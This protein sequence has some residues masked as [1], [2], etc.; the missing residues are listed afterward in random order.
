MI[1]RAILGIVLCATLVF[2][3]QYTIAQTV[4]SDLFHEKGFPFLPFE[5]LLE[6]PQNTGYLLHALPSPVVKNSPN[7]LKS[8]LKAYSEKN[9]RESK[10]YTTDSTAFYYSGTNDNSDKYVTNMVNFN[11]IVSFT[12]YSSPGEWNYTLHPRIDSMKRFKLDSSGEFKCYIK[13]EGKIDE[14]GHLVNLTGFWLKNSEYWEP[15]DRYDYIYDD[16]SFLIA[17]NAERFINGVWEE[18]HKMSF[19]YD[20]SGRPLDNTVYIPKGSG[21]YENLDRMLFEYNQFGSLTSVRYEYWEGNKWKPTLRK[22]RE[23]NSNNQVTKFMSQSW[24]DSGNKWSTSYQYDFEYVDGKYRS[25]I[26]YVGSY[27]SGLIPIEKAEY[28]FDDEG[29]NLAIWKYK[30]DNEWKIT[31]MIDLSYTDGLPH[32]LTWVTMKEG[33]FVDYLRQQYYHNEYDQR[34]FTMTQMWDGE[35]G[36]WKVA[37]K[38]KTIWYYYEEYDETAVTNHK[39][40]TIDAKIFPNPSTGLISVEIN[41]LPID[42]IR[43]MDINGKLM[44][45]SKFNMNVSKVDVP[46]DRLNPGAYYMLINTGSSRVTRSFIVAK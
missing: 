44:Y 37:H 25:I 19:T 42:R 10:Y 4:S 8:R 9:V 14:K 34:T 7:A 38:E 39:V 20:S 40:N 6:K 31:D 11:D 36:K 15:T 16:Q 43:I 41:E 30:W 45:D 1:T 23:Y 2:N 5:E 35:E 13:T 32:D 28:L 17:L 18:N 46:T 3:H 27:I 12:D 26:T 29:K 22:F 21:N 24:D 33:V